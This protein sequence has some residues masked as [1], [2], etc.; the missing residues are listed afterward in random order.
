MHSSLTL[1]LNCTEGK[2]AWLVVYVEVGWLVLYS[3]LF[4][5]VY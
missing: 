2:G 1:G 3:S 4:Y 5:C